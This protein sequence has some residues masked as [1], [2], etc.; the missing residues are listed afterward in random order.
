MHA[1]G[2]VHH[3]QGG[4]WGGQAAEGSRQGSFPTQD[5]GNIRSQALEP[6][7]VSPVPCRTRRSVLAAQVTRHA[8][9]CSWWDSRKH[10]C[11]GACSLVCLAGRADVWQQ[12]PCTASSPWLPAPSN[13]CTGTCRRPTAFQAQ[14]SACR[15]HTTAGRAGHRAPGS[16][17]AAALTHMGFSTCRT[18]HAPHAQ[19]AERGTWER[20]GQRLDAHGLQAGEGCGCC[21]CGCHDAVHQ[22]AQAVHQHGQHGQR[23]PLH[24]TAGLS[25]CHC[26]SRRASGQSTSTASVGSRCLCSPYPPDVTPGAGNW[27]QAWFVSLPQA[28]QKRRPAALCCS[29]YPGPCIH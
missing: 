1:G 26:C 7:P 8:P 20:A 14:G 13:P 18:E 12:Q 24:P 25:G 2:A 3:E 23:V 29:S 4:M 19:Q 27:Q 10:K 28:Q 22:G 6:L 9:N 11:M 5:Q 21:R 16:E 15:S 17:L